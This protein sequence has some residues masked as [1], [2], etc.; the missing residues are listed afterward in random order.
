MIINTNQVKQIYLATN[1]TDMRKSIDGLASIIVSEFDLDICEGS[2]FIFTN[3]ACNRLKILYYDKTGFW[4]FLKKLD[5][6]RFK[7]KEDKNNHTKIIETR[8]L[9]WLL[10]G[11]EIDQ[12]TAFKSAEKRYIY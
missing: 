2:L 9:S 3:K 10:D 8:Q 7:L 11:L 5:K 12:K 4:L 6:G 1:Y